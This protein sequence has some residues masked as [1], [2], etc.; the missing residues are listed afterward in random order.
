MSDS[1]NQS[2]KPRSSVGAW[3]KSVDALRVSELPPEALNLNVEGRRAVGP[4]QGFGQLWQKT[5]RIRL[6]GADVTPEQVIRTWKA[7]LPRF[8]PAG[9]RFYPPP[10]GVAPGEVVLIN[11]WTPGGPVATGVVVL[12]S[13]DESFT[14]MTPQGH[15]ESGWVTLSAFREGDTTVAQIHA[16]ARASDPLYEL[17]F[18]LVG[19]RIQDRIWSHVLRS[20]AANW[21]VE[22]Q[23]QLDKVLLDPKV[24]W[25]RTANLWHNAQIRTALYK[26]TAPLRW[27]RDRVTEGI[28]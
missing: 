25:S 4:L 3:A 17:A 19:S 11:A 13:D 18:R 28:G 2:Q 23:V 1:P 9:Q 20:L 15:P 24:Q 5:Y 27:I 26:L 21:G 16:I 22:A 10:K 12:F 14:L 7:D 6:T 8:K